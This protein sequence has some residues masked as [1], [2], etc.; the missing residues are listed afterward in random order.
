M[1][2]LSFSGSISTWTVGALSLVCPQHPWEILAT[3]QLVSGCSHSLGCSQT[4]S[5][6]RFPVFSS[7]VNA[8]T[9]QLALFS[10][11]QKIS[12]WVIV[13]PQCKPILIFSNIVPPTNVSTDIQNLIILTYIKAERR[14]NGMELSKW[15]VDG[16]KLV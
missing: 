4:T 3:E 10:P 7:N 15:F 5:S 1:W 2:D 6:P 16:L 12:V 14:A 13:Q 9:F 8:S 11:F